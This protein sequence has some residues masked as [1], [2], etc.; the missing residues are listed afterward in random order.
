[1]VQ[2]ST[3][4]GSTS[5]LVNGTAKPCTITTNTQYTVI[6]IASNSSFNLY[7]QSQTTTI[8]INQLKF[9]FSSSHSNYLY[10]FYFQLTVSLAS[11]ASVQKYL[12]V[13]MVVQ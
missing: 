6:K 9:L 4:L 8:Q 1:M 12:A 10:H 2:D 5:C 13:P 7:P 11:L 3:F